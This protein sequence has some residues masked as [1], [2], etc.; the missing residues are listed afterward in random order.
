MPA[1]LQHSRGMLPGKLSLARN[2]IGEVTGCRG[3]GRAGRE[4]PPE[5]WRDLDSIAVAS[6]LASDANI[7][8]LVGHPDP[9]LLEPD[10]PT[11]GG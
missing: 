6:Y 10:P 11:R 3:P 4:R 8:Q 7:L 1:L 5:I 9:S 2:A